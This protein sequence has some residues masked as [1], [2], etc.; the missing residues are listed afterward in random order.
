MDILD[1]STNAPSWLTLLQPEAPAP[2][3]L[4]LDFPAYNL[5]NRTQP[6]TNMQGHISITAAKTVNSTH[7]TMLGTNQ[8]I[9]SPSVT[10]TNLESED[11]PYLAV[12]DT[13]MEFVRSG[14]I[15]VSKGKL[16]TLTGNTATIAPSNEH[17][18]DIAAL[19]LATG[20][21]ASSSISFLPESV[22]ETLSIS[23]SDLN[24]TVA[25]AFHGT[26]HPEVPNLGFVGFYRSPYWGVMEMQAR[27]VTALW[28]AGGPG[29]SSLSPE[30]ATA[31][32]EDTSISRTI[33]LRNNPR[34]SQFPMG[35]YP[36]LM[37]EFATALGLARSPVPESMPRLPPA[38]RQMDIITPSRYTSKTLSGAQ[39][40]E[41]TKS[42]QQTEKT[43]MAGMTSGKFVAKAVFRSLLGEWKLE[44]DLISKL[45]SHPS[46]HFS[47][48][49]KFLLRKGTRD[50]RE[51]EFDALGPDGDPGLEYLYIEE[52]DFKAS[53]GL[54]FRATR[55]YVWRYNEKTDK[56]SVWFART[57]D[58][59]KA[60]Y[61]FHHVEF[62]VPKPDMEEVES[63]RGW[64]A[65]AGH[66]CIDDFYDVNYLFNFK[67]VNLRDWTLGYTVKGPKKDYRID[68]V[69]SR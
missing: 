48:I 24:N 52:G 55:R 33:E 51:S 1:S 67:A 23:P 17:I 66:L 69:Y 26:Y 62:E 46:G 28:A 40:Q 9:F 3:F 45:P 58:Q 16:E 18:H 25:L 21:E 37:Q 8:S 2:R 14:L 50:G 54:T 60:D 39:Q 53:N 19:V 20:F 4:P 32:A 29:S 36:W 7:E 12:S 30:L 11:P 57:D 6:L 31:L 42:L 64:Q 47:G 68:G 61:L 13:Y 15:S 63:R 10:I 41:V 22:R 35:D 65:T 34:A 56:L 27:F 43:I 38:G 59:K 5:A 44:R 49:A